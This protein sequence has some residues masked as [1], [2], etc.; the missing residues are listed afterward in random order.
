MWA[1]WDTP[2]DRVARLR[3]DHERINL[4]LARWPTDAVRT[5]AWGTDDDRVT[6]F[7][8]ATESATVTEQFDT[9]DID[10]LTY[11]RPAH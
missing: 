4:A 5:I 1:W 9:V 10:G 11:I 2:D 3:L 8:G 7:R 6:A